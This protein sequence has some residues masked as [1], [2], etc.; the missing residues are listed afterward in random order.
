MD[1]G[2][3]EGGCSAAC[4]AAARATACCA[5]ATRWATTARAPRTSPATI[6]DNPGVSQSANAQ[7]TRSVISALPDR[8][9]SATSA[10]AR[11]AGLLP[12]TRVYPMTD[13]VT[14]DITAFEPD[15][16][17]PYG[18]RGRRAGSASS[19]R[20]MAVEA[21]YVGTR[22][23]QSW[24]DYNYNESEHRRE[25]LPQRVPVS[26]RR[27]SQA[28]IAAGRGS[29]FRYFGPGTGTSPLPI[30]LA[31]FNGAR[32]AARQH[33]ELQQLQF[34]RA[35]TFVNDLAKYNPDPYNSQHRRPRSI[36]DATRRDNALKAG[37]PANFLV[38]NPDL[39]RRRR[40]HR[41]RRRAPSTT[42][43][44][45]N[46]ASGCPTASS[47]AP[48]MSSARPTPPPDTRCVPARARCWTPAPKAASRMRSS[49]NWIYELPFGQGTPLR[50]QRRT[51]CSTGSIGGWSFDGIARIQSGTDARLRQRA[52]RRHVD[53]T[54]CRTTS[55]SASTTPESWSTCCRRTSSTRP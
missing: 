45:S 35:R 10:D 25:R 19:A 2:R 38:A 41:Q 26:R 43:C 24:Q 54:I 14:G 48:A 4:S 47:S 29:N 13:V 30:F 5:P 55:S 6:D 40:H 36:G 34:R 8:S 16:Q 23:L 9:C 37:L 20:D 3:Q 46:C 39:P 32:S 12:T 33:G 22:S 49:A 31:Y 15:L 42:R 1:V 28:N 44:S 52:P 11:S 7:T 50:R 21:R 51:V 18:R 53:R 17:V 27:T